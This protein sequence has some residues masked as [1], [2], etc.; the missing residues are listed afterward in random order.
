MPYLVIQRKNA[1]PW[2]DLF[3]S[4]PWSMEHY[5]LILFI[6]AFEIVVLIKMVHM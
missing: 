3:L 2:I 1:L 6:N 4:G 5:N